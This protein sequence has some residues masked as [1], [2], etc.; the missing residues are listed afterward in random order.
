MAP[1]WFSAV[2]A[3]L[4]KVGLLKAGG[5]KTLE[6]ELTARQAGNLT[7]QV[8]VRADGNLHAELAEKVLVRR[9][10]LKIDFDGP[11]V[12]FVDTVANY[13][14]TVFNPGNAPAR[15]VK[16]SLALPSGAKYLSGIEGARVDSSG[17]KLVWI[18]DSLG[19]QEERHFA[20]K[21]RLAAAGLSRMKLNAVAVTFARRAA[22]VAAKILRTSS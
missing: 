5:K 15:N 3:R 9:A 13:A 1:V 20:I 17:G 18:L 22:G 6:V 16:F 4:H 8:E 10:G 19:A 11:K 14:V 21:C 7:V 2:I 12:Q